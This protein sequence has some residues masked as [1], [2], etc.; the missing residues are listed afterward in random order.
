MAAMFESSVKA[1]VY[2]LEAY[3]GFGLLF[4]VPFVWFGVQRLDSAARG[5]GIAFRL[6]ILPASRRY[7]RCSSTAGG[8]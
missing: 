7:G 3:A 4:A 8:E 1:L 5:S 2:A 6:V